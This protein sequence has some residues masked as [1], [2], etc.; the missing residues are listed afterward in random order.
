MIVTECEILDAM[1]HFLEFIRDDIVCQLILPVGHRRDSHLQAI[2]AYL[3]RFDLLL[4]PGSIH[5]VAS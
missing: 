3:E 1:I 5:L 4:F 2:N